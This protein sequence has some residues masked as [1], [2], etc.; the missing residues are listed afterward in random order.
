MEA[1]RPLR[2]LHVMDS[3]GEGG[4]EQNLLTLVRRLGPKQALHGL[5][6]LYEDDQLGEAFRPHVTAMIPL[7]T[8]RQFGIFPAAFRLAREMRKF[9]PDIVHAKLIRAQLLARLA[10]WLAGGVPVISTWECVS[11]D[12][13]MYAQ[14]GLKGLAL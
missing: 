8:G 7:H 3:L 2:I 12:K 4:A 11:Y 6:W 14:W 5:A 1:R 9:Q 13:L 10:S